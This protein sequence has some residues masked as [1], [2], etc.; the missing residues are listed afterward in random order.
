MR[1]FGYTQQEIAD[2]LGIPRQTITRWLANMGNGVRAK[3]GNSKRLPTIPRCALLTIDI[4]LHPCR[5]EEA[6][7]PEETVDLI[8]TDPPYLASSNNLSRTLQKTDLR[9]DYGK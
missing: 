4:N 7:I 1:E 2:T 8:L 5:Y 3:V 9:R 6:S